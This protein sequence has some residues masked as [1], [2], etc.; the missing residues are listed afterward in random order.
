MKRASIR[1]T[2]A[3]LELQ[4]VRKLINSPSFDSAVSS[5]PGVEE[6]GGVV[7]F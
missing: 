1:D 6:G 4:K 5:H 2:N 3:S 7:T